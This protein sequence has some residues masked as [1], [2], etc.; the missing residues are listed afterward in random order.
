MSRICNG[1]RQ[2]HE[3]ITA[4]LLTRDLWG[5]VLFPVF[6]LSPILY[7]LLS[8]PRGTIHENMYVRRRECFRLAAVLYVTELRAKF[9]VDASP[10][11]LY[12]SKLRNMLQAGDMLRPWGPS[13]VFLLWSLTV[14][15]SSTCVLEGLRRG[16]VH[17][18]STAAQAAGIT[19]FP[20]LVT[21]FATFLWCDETMALS[22]RALETKYQSLLD[23]TST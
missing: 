22:V 8:M 15:A 1:L 13:N 21:L 14:A 12:A 2:V 18:L 10:A 3:I 9:G 6:H 17:M 5:D 11:I 20:E 23:V 16:F 7:D 19:R 4:E